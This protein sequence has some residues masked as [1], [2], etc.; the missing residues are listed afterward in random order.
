MSGMTK[1]KT[2]FFFFIPECN[3]YYSKIVQMSGMAKEKTKVFFFFLE[4]SLS[5]QKNI[6]FVP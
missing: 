2:K 5:Y 1:G 6:L 3:L 4:C